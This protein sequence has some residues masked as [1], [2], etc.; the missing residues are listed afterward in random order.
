MAG[1]Q[2]DLIVNS[3]MPVVAEER[4]IIQGDQAAVEGRGVERLY[5]MKCRQIERTS[6]AFVVDGTPGT[7]VVI[8]QTGGRIPKY[9][10]AAIAERAHDR[11]V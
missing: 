8:S 6:L 5:A 7:R 3:P 4:C 2:A 11:S 9:G 1:H 10:S